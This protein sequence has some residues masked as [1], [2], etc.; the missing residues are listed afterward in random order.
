MQVITQLAVRWVTCKFCSLDLSRKNVVLHKSAALDLFADSKKKIALY[1]NSTLNSANI[2]EFSNI[3]II[4]TA[5]KKSV[6]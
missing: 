6:F 4:S 5:E 3:F 1:K 2:F